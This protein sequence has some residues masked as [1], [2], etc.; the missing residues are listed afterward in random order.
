MF[1]NSNTKMC[2][3]NIE[4]CFFSSNYHIIVRY[5]FHI[6]YTYVCQSKTSCHYVNLKCAMKIGYISKLQQSREWLKNSKR[7]LVVP[8]ARA[9]FSRHELSCER[10]LIIFINENISKRLF[11]AL[12][13]L[14]AYLSVIKIIDIAYLNW[15]FVILMYWPHIPIY[16]IFFGNP[17]NLIDSGNFRISLFNI[18]EHLCFFFFSLAHT[19]YSDHF[20]S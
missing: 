20:F 19:L 18:S 4:L 8:V 5:R 9:Q 10:I 13:W 1:F 3:I 17:N 16:S 12:W 15:T 6:Q 2:W 14:P 7:S 11:V